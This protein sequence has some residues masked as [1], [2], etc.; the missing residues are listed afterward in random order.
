[1]TADQHVLLA[2]VL[3][4]THDCIKL[5]DATGRIEFVNRQGAVVMELREPAELVGR[6]WLDRW[7]EESRPKIAEALARAQAGEHA[8]FSAARPRP[9]GSRSWW[10][11]TVSPIM[12]DAGALT[13]YLTI[14]RDTTREIVEQERAEAISAEMRHRLKNALTIA[15]ALVNM[16]AR[17]R[18][19]L[20]DFAEAI[21]QR[22]G[23]IASVQALVLDPEAKKEFRDIIPM[24][25]EAYG[26]LSALEFG[27]IPDVSLGNNALQ[28]LAL[29]FGELCTNSLKYGAFK[30][31]RRIHVAGEATEG[32]LYL[33]WREETRFGRARKGG[34]GLGLIERIVHASGGH[35]ERIVDS[36][37]LQVR[38]ALP[39]NALSRRPSL[40][41]DPHIR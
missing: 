37:R 11:V 2:A 21:C 40:S 41:T 39:T 10:D 15:S 13:H 14:A 6:L 25:A 35:V 22:F 9:D 17:A 26:D 4:Q 38:I 12:S 36:D 8:R 27:D 5:L 1:M 18:P 28:A 16:S 19:E 23:Q 32:M 30:T 20:E 3:D 29:A 31:G 7:P 33:V 34:Q 24:L